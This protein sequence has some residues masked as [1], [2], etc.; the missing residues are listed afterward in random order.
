[1]YVF[2]IQKLAT[3]I[4]FHEHLLPV[5][6]PPPNMKQLKPDVMCTVIG[7]GKRRDKDRKSGKE[8]IVP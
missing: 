7:W 3:R 2:R 4:A 8:T 6:L 5:C 1:M